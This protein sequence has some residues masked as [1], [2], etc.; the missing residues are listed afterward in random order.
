MS[1][2]LRFDGRT[3]PLPVGELL[4]GRDEQCQLVVDDPN[5]SRMHLSLIV[6]QDSV[7][8]RDLGSRNGVWLEGK[9]VVSA[10]RAKPGDVIRLGDTELVLARTSEAPQ[11]Q[12]RRRDT[13]DIDVTTAPATRVGVQMVPPAS[14]ARPAS[15]LPLVAGL[16]DKSLAQGR[17]DEAERIAEGTLTDLLRDAKKGVVDDALMQIATRC[18]VKLATATERGRW[19]DY[20]FDLHA[21]PGA[22]LPT[23]VVDSLYDL[24]RRVPDVSR[25]RLRDYVSRLDAVQPTLSATEKFSV[26]RIAGLEAVIASAAPAGRVPSGRAPARSR[27][28][29]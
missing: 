11:V 10:Q 17:V 8:V 18:A 14:V 6:T 1:F 26:R 7:H 2:L 15:S 23:P 27:P 16:A 28:E 20:L 24:V 19:I 3:I 4:V 5:V 25:G 29:H 21:A 9:R 22:V 13:L 12:S